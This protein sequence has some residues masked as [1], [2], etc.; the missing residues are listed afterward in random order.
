MLQV[1]GIGYHVFSI[2]TVVLPAKTKQSYIH[3]HPHCMSSAAPFETMC[4]RRTSPFRRKTQVIFFLQHFRQFYLH[5]AHPQNHQS[6]SLHLCWI[7]RSKNH[8]TRLLSFPLICHF[9]IT[10]IFF[11]IWSSYL[12][13]TRTYDSHDLPENPSPTLLLCQFFFN[14]F[15]KFSTKIPPI[16]S[17]YSDHHSFYLRLLIP[18]NWFPCSHHL[19]LDSIYPFFSLFTAHTLLFF[20]NKNFSQ[21]PNLISNFWN[22]KIIRTPCPFTS[23]QRLGANSFINFHEKGF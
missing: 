8:F 5:H 20:F 16:S 6:V 11:A 17:L 10:L 23:Y 3:F 4:L 14:F 15:S 9:I 22:P 13:P 1:P 21:H 18:I 12:G 19:L 7:S 2:F